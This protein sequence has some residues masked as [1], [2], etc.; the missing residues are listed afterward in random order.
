M[1]LIFT[2][3]WTAAEVSLRISHM[4]QRGIYFGV[5]GSRRQPEQMGEIIIHRQSTGEP[6]ATCLNFSQWT[7]YKR[8]IQS[9][10]LQLL[11]P[12]GRGRLLIGRALSQVI[13][14]S[15][16]D[17]SRPETSYLPGGWNKSG[18]EVP[19]HN[20]ATVQCLQITP[21]NL[22][23]NRTSSQRRC[24]LVYLFLLPLSI[25]NAKKGSFYILRLA[26]LKRKEAAASLQLFGINGWGREQLWWP[27]CLPQM[28]LAAFLPF[29]APCTL[30]SLFH[31]VICQVDS[32]SHNTFLR[33]CLVPCKR[34]LQLS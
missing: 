6:Q 17:I 5:S 33:R 1:C 30:I 23:G 20:S 24:Y 26:D 8:G 29:V 7:A 10:W 9:M 4:T 25:R 14:R 2:D 15:H 34:Q 32:I 13:N 28:S 11:S 18:R 21:H 31:R 27:P 12:P 3:S 22:L 16:C 19:A